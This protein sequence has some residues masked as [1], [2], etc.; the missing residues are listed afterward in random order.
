MIDVHNETR[1]GS[2]TVKKNTTCLF[3]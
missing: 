1:A 3:T 2:G